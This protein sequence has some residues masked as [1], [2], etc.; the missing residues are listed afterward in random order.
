MKMTA[1]HWAAIRDHPIIIKILLSRGAFV[2]EIDMTH[3]TPLYLAARNGSLNAVEMLIANNANPS[4]KTNSKKLP[5][6]SAKTKEITNCISK[7]MNIRNT[8]NKLS[9]LSRFNK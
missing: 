3:R 8:I 5:I 6:S 4:I 7:A 2:D 1:L 9:L